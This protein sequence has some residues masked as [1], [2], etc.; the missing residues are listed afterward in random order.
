MRKYTCVPHCMPFI[1]FV[2]M[3]MH[4]IGHFLLSSI[5]QQMRSFLNIKD[6][7]TKVQKVMSKCSNVA[8]FVYNRL[9]RLFCI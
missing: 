6:K 1:S 2:F 7:Y 9:K 3:V 4:I 5:R 8:T